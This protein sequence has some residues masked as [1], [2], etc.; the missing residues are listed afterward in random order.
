MAVA[1]SG[2]VVW[3]IHGTWSR[4]AE[5]THPVSPLVKTL[6]AALGP[7]V[8][9]ETLVWRGRNRMFDRHS[10]VEQLCKAVRT[11]GWSPGR[12]FAVALATAA[13]SL[14]TPCCLDPKLFDG[15]VTLNTPFLNEL[16][17]SSRVLGAHAALLVLGALIVPTAYLHQ[18][19]ALELLLGLLIGAAIALVGVFLFSGAIAI[20]DASRVSEH[21]LERFLRTGKWPLAQA[22]E[23]APVLCINTTDDEPFGW[24][25]AAAA[26]INL[27]YLLLHR[28]GFLV[29]F[30]G[31][32]LLHWF[33]RWNFGGAT[34]DIILLALRDRRSGTA[35][36]PSRFMTDL[37]D[38][39]TSSPVAITATQLEY[40]STWIWD[41]A[42]APAL[43]GIFAFSVVEHYIMF[44]CMLALVSLLVSFV[45]RG[46]AFGAGFSRAALVASLAFRHKVTLTPLNVTNAQLML[47]T[48]AA[49]TLQHSA[50]HTK[51]V[52]GRLAASWFQAASGLPRPEHDS[53]S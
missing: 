6:R 5:W 22:R 52:I 12:T 16:P 51:E 40:F 8:T 23:S 10:A 25:D 36:G 48:E 11:R 9:I 24:L 28:L 17:R 29:I 15:V 37:Y 41:H 39:Y 38:Y 27:P 21:T 13:T 20:V 31:M 7:D 42:P 35:S 19:P 45:V 14:R 2:P 4:H 46:L 30:V 53:P 33:Q 18:S 43:A 1:P 50:L 47:M 49:G 26:L 44:W 34:V 3:L 32:A